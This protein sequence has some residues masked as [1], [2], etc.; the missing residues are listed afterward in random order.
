MSPSL[1]GMLGAVITLIT[2]PYFVGVLN[3][4]KASW[5]GRRGAPLLQPYYDIARLL[6]KQVVVSRVATP[7]FLF[8][9]VARLC[10]IVC[11]LLVVPT[12][13]PAAPL[14]FAFDFVVLAYA[15]GAG[16][17]LLVLAALD[18][19]SPF[20][21][22]GASR[23]LTFSAF[24]EPCLFI[25]FA[26][27]QAASSGSTSL[28]QLLGHPPAS[29][30]EL[31]IRL[32]LAGILFIILQTEG[33]RIP[34]DDPTTHLELT[35]IHEV[36]VLDHSGPELASIQLSAALNLSLLMGM[37]TSLIVVLPEG[38][39]LAAVI[40]VRLLTFL[41]LTGAVAMIES[42]SGRF[43]MGTVTRYITTAMAVAVLVL[44]A[45]VLSMSVQS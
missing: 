40:A 5:A 24:T 15:L 2:A 23:E 34:V 31:A 7:L 18:T 38:T 12:L 39:P 10:A 30:M 43:R 17:V 4:I 6:R 8:A 29:A 9:P 42:L 36:M 3:R 33:C 32:A 26:T 41:A 27:L 44:G 11:A 20:E 14:S 28:Q 16:R 1:T 35:M 19:G 45:M 37:I 25:V 21:G 22:M 13:T